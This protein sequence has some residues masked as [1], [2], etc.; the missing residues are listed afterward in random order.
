MPVFRDHNAP[1]F[2]TTYQLQPQVGPHNSLWTRLKAQLMYTYIS[3]AWRGVDDYVY[4]LVCYNERSH[5]YRMLQRTVFIKK[6]RKLQRTQMLQR[7]RRNTIGRRSTRMRMTR[8]GF[9]LWL[10]R[11]S[12][13]LLS[14]VRFSYQFSSVICLFAPLAEKIFF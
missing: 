7:N 8:R 11:Q 4:S 14:F 3:K 1:C 9:P 13:S 6:I 5:N 12:S 2:K 10:E